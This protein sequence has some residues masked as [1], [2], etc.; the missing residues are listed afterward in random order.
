M[1]PFSVKRCL[2]EERARFACGR[3][4]TSTPGHTFDAWTNAQGEDIRV[5]TLA[6]FNLHSLVQ[7][8]CIDHPAMH[9]APISAP[10]LVHLFVINVESGPGCATAKCFMLARSAW[11]D[12]REPTS[13]C[14]YS[15]YV[16][17][18]DPTLGQPRGPI[19]RA[20][21]ACSMHD[22]TRQAQR[23]RRSKRQRRSEQSPARN[24]RHV[25]AARPT[26]S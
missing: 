3:S 2:L 26:V 12:Q 15:W 18:A 8:Y 1:Q 17:L 23:Q 10:T 24:G 25:L 21:S 11:G 6:P 9:S 7:S 13:Q 4:E 19:Q 14:N 16:S 5:C 20:R 22:K